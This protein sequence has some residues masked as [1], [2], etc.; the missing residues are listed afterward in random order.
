MAG[1]GEDALTKLIEGG[2]AEV[3]IAEVNRR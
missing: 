1:L 3:I 2:Q